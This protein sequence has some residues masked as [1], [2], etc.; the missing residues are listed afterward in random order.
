MLHQPSHYPDR[1]LHPQPKVTTFRKSSNPLFIF[2]TN[3]IT[4]M[5]PE[6]VQCV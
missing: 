6:E 1:T 5:I 2:A 4:L 3:I